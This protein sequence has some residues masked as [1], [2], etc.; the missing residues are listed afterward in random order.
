MMQNMNIWISAPPPIIDFPASLGLAYGV[1]PT[2]L[3]GLLDAQH[4]I[5]KLAF[6]YIFTVNVPLPGRYY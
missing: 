1:D 5:C 4:K 6:I 2:P 3:K